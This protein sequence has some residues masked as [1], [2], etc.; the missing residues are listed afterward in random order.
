MIDSFTR[1]IKTFFEN[2][3]FMWVKKYFCMLLINSS[4]LGGVWEKETTSD[5]QELGI[6]KTQLTKQTHKLN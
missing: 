2:M 6:Q 1:K 5:M 4:M 3:R